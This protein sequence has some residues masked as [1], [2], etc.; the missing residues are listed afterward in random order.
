MHGKSHENETH[1]TSADTLGSFL[2]RVRRDAD[3]TLVQVAGLAD[4]LPSTISR[5][6]NGKRLAPNS[7]L[8]KRLAN[9]LELDL[10]DLFALSSRSRIIPPPCTLADHLMHEA[11]F[12]LPDAAVAKAQAAL[13]AIIDE[14]RPRLGPD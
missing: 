8:L 12:P 14:Y 10:A 7:E 11:G 1:P 6:E 2:R 3:M 9:A 4:T 5:I 13:R